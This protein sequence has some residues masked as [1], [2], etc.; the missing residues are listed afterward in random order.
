MNADDQEKMAHIARAFARG[1]YRYTIHAAQQRIARAVRRRDIEAVVA[2]GQVIED[3]P[4]HHYGPCCLILGSTDAGGP[5]HLVCSLRQI[6][7]IIT[8]YEPDL[9]EWEPDL[10][11]RRKR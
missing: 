7:D 2:G 10:K 4:E 1:R 11:T 8:V 6:V 5:L 3:Y 9:D